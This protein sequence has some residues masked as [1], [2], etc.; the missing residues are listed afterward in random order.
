MLNRRH[1]LLVVFFDDPELHDFTLSPQEKEIE[2]FEHVIAEKMLYDRKL[3]VS[4]LRQ[5]GIYSLL[6]TPNQLTVDVINKYLEMK[7]RQLLT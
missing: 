6:T 3:I 7:S 5:N 2:Y 4:T 1:R